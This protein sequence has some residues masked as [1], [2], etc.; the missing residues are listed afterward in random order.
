MIQA[1]EASAEAYRRAEATPGDRRFSPYHALNRLA[2]RALFPS[3]PADRD[4]AVALAR[5]C[6]MAA[7]LS[8]E[9]SPNVWDAAMQ[10]EALLVERLIDRTLG[11]ADEAGQAAFGEVVRAYEHAMSNVTIKPSQLDSVL[12]QMELLARFSEALSRADD[13]AEW[14]GLMAERLRQLIRRLQP[15]RP[16]PDVRPTAPPPSKQAPPG[17]AGPPAASESVPRKSRPARKPRRTP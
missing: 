7:A 17:T 10:A 14:F 11:R 4:A 2:V 8:Y 9:R 3:E 12:T 5:E 16:T 1:L 15:G 13:E 6:R